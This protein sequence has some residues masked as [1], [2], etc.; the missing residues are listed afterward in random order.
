MKPESIVLFFIGVTLGVKLIWKI[1][2]VASDVSP[3]PWSRE[4]DLAVRAKDA[5][6]VCMDCLYPQE[7]RLWFCPHCGFP[8]G[9]CNNVMPYLQIFSLGE[10]LRRGVVGSPE[11]GLTLK[12]GFVLYSFEY[13]LFAPIY[14]F[15]MERKACGKPI[16]QAQRKELQFEETV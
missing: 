13:G 1:R 10:L 14:W 3:D 12:L 8:A 16:C 2:E 6:P 9:E 11:K 7:E 4:V 15:W 5:I